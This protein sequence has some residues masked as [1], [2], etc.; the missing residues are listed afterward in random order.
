MSILTVSN[1]SLPHLLEFSLV[2]AFSPTA[3]P[4][5]LLTSDQWPLLYPVV[6]SWSSSCSA[7]QQPW[8]ELIQPFFLDHCLLLASMILY[9]SDRTSSSFS[10]SFAGFFPS[11][12]GLYVGEPQVPVLGPHSCFYPFLWR[13]NHTALNTVSVLKI[14]NCP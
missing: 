1:L 7:C 11:P 9:S 4:K 14:P 2:R 3:L 13:S 8:R 5:L 10:L 6:N 12:R